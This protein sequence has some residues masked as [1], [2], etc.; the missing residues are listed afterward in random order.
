M[1]Q[2]AI[3]ADM[4]H[5]LFKI[6]NRKCLF[7]FQFFAIVCHEKDEQ[8]KQMPRGKKCMKYAMIERVL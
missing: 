6:N 7:L 3:S 8:Q 1:L 4:R 2:N 5:K